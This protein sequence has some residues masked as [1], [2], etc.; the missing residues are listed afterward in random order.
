LGTLL[1]GHQPAPP[2]QSCASGHCGRQAMTGTLANQS[3]SKHLRVLIIEDVPSDAEIEIA[4]LR[5]NGFDVSS[6]VVDT[7][8]RVR[9]RLARTAYDVILADYSLPNF[10]GMDT[11]DILQQ[12]NLNTPVILV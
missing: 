12:K 7:G 3:G 11:P 1:D 8:D 10:R 6:D 9:E 5:R 4:E 2:C